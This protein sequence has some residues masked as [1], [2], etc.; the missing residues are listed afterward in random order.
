M[1]TAKKLNI[2][3]KDYLVGEPLSDVKHEFINGAVY[4]MAGGTKDHNTICGNIFGE[5]RQQLKGQPCRPFFADVMVKAASHYFY[6]DVMLV[7]EPDK[8]DNERLIHAPTIVVEVLSSSTRIN[9][10]TFKKIA[11]LNIPSLQEYWLVE[12]DR[13]EIEVFRRSENWASTYH[14]LGDT[15]TSEIIGVSLTVADIY[16]EVENHKI[17][18]LLTNP[19]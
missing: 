18:A 7:C 16:A 19:E 4:A 13:C 14:V 9:D 10:L 6:P 15:I 12:Q 5:W 3:E 1:S 8:R 11:Y 2:S 17:T